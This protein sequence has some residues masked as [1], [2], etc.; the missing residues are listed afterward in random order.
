MRRRGGGYWEWADCQL[1]NQR[2]AESLSDGSEIEVLVRLSRDGLTQVFIG[3]Y[4]CN[5]QMLCEECHKDCGSK[6][7]SEAMEW[8]VERARQLVVAAA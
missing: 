8:G 4:A 6:T 2:H 3:I 5:G 1:A 7:R